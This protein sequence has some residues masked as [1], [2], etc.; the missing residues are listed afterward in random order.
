MRQDLEW[1]V[2]KGKENPCSIA[3]IQQKDYKCIDSVTDKTH[4]EFKDNV[5][6]RNVNY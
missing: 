2:H 4:Q 6:F 3:Q 5:I 1:L